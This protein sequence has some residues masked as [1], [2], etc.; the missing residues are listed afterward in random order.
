MIICWTLVR[1]T[2][3]S[4]DACRSRR[5]QPGLQA[6]ELSRNLQPG[7]GED[8]EEHLVSC[9]GKQEKE[10]DWTSEVETVTRCCLSLSLCYKRALQAKVGGWGWGR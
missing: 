7:R 5:P 1:H 3:F 6:M 4:Q 9:A 2:D 8:C 10:L